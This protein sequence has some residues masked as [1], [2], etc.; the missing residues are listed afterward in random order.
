M[1]VSS[2][3]VSGMTIGTGAGASG[4]FVTGFGNAAIQNKM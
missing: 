1:V 2:S 4:G 3:F